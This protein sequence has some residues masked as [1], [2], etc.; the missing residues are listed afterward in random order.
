MS[1]EQFAL[2]DA[3]ERLRE[4]RRTA[5]DDRLVTISAADPLNLTGIITP[6]DR[7]RAVAANRIVYCNGVP[8]AAMEGD[9]LR[10]LSPVDPAMAPLSRRPPPDAACPCSA[11]T[12]AGSNRGCL[13][14]SGAG[15]APAAF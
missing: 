10:V 11:D 1:G 14:R 6:G 15:V 13:K 9:M 3:V 2:P 5:P 12:S 7:I 4:V 8:V